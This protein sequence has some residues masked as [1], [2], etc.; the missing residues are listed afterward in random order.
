MELRTLEPGLIVVFI[1]ES[2]E[3]RTSEPGLIVVFIK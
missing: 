1:K 2:M 3:L